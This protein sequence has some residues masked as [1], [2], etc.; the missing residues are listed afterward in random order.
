MK[1]VSLNLAAACGILI[2]GSVAVRSQPLT[3]RTLAGNT[4]AGSTNGFGSNARFNHPSGTAAD[5]AG[6]VYVTDTENG[7]IRKITPDGFAGSLAGLAGHFGSGS[8]TGTNARF[9]GPQGIASD[10]SGN[11]IVADTANATIRKIT[12]GGTVSTLAGLPGTFNSYDGAGANANFY[13]PEGVALD[14][15]G[16]VY[17]ADAWN[18]TIRRITPAGVVTTL[19]GLAGTP[20]GMD[21]TNSKARFNRPGGVA[22]DAATNIFVTDSLNHT[23]RKITPAGSVSTIAGLTGVWGSTDGTNS[24]ARFFQPHGI[25]ALGTNT[26]LVVDSGNQIVRKIV[27]NGTNWVISTVAGLTEVNG[28]TNGSGSAAQFNFPAGIALDN[29]GYLYV[30]DS[31]NHLIR[32]TRVVSPTLQ[33]VATQNQ[34]ALSWPVSSE[35][36]ALEFSPGVE[37]G[38]LWLP[39]TNGV[40][41]NG[42]NFALTNSTQAAAAFYRLHKP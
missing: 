6:N 32:T 8:G 39:V 40:F 11:L 9:Y 4:A 29:A 19:A 41:I 22:V 16:N 35:G 5:A 3:I 1:T 12:P 23:I 36:F 37:P 14:N 18:H 7:T 42:D 10:A 31:G 13:Q 38:S 34:L 2:A 21:G 25:I 24:A 28:S 26:L 17:I 20:G 30:V 15:G 27:A 33:S